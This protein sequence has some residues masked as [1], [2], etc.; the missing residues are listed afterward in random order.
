MGQAVSTMETFRWKD[1]VDK[2]GG[3]RGGGL[4]Q[5]ASTVD[6]SHQ[7][8]IE[9]KDKEHLVDTNNQHQITRCSLYCLVLEI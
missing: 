8:S 6:Y 9:R 4:G 5:A 7:I 3:C 2:G 1:G